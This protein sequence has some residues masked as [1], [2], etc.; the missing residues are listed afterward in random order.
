MIRPLVDLPF[1]VLG[2]LLLLALVVYGAVWSRRRDRPLWWLRVLAVLLL[3]AIGL[4]P[5]LGSM[6]TETV[7]MPLEIVVAVDRTTSMSARDWNGDDPRLDGARRD[8]ADLVQALPSGRFTLVTFGR[9]VRTELPSTQDET[10]IAETLG[11]IRR[12]PIFAGTGSRLD[13]P[14]THLRRLLAGMKEQKPDRPRLLVIMGDGE[15]TDFRRQKSYAPLQ[16]FVDAGAVFGYGTTSG[17]LMPTDERQPDGGWVI[18]PATG[19]P[20]RSRLDEANLRAVADELDVPFLHRQKP[21]GL[22]SLVSSVERAFSDTAAD[23]GQEAQARFELS[24]LLALG[25]LP[26]ALIE[27]SRHG[28]RLRETR[29]EVA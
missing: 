13:L 8:T 10:L 3:F 27:L 12:E 24:W 17:G 4:R 7:V 16:P 20:A 21:G 1:L 28:R 29:R 15:N 26:V 22:G 2:S 23:T 5:G 6:P 19:A 9:S 14:L 11:L 18:D 25:L